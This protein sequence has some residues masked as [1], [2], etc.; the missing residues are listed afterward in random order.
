MNYKL[1]QDLIENGE[2]DT[3][4]NSHIN[5][6]GSLAEDVRD[7]KKQYKQIKSDI[8]KGIITR[9]DHNVGINRISNY[10]SELIEKLK[11]FK[12]QQ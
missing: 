11:A 12:A 10:L 1:L 3:L 5:D 4:F 7:L 2:F 9:E 6:F 8:R